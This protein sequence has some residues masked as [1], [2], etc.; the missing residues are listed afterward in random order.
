VSDESTNIE[1]RESETELYLHLD[2]MILQEGHCCDIGE[3]ET[4]LSKYK[5]VVYDG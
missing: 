3:L 1:V 2:S 5:A 4:L